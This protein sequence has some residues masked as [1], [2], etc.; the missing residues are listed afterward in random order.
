MLQLRRTS[1]CWNCTKEKRK[2][3]G[4][5]RGGDEEAKRPVVMSCNFKIKQTKLEKKKISRII[6]FY[7]ISN[8][9]SLLTCSVMVRGMTRLWFV[10]A[11]FGKTAAKRKSLW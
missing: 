5:R 11:A 1:L 8:C 4:G 7:M 2:K 9:V 10:C 3:K 6:L